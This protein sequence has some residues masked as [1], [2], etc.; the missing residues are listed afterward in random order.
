MRLVPLATSAAASG[1]SD[2]STRLSMGPIRNV[3]LLAVACLSEMSYCAHE[4]KMGVIPIPFI[5]GFTL[6]GVL[7]NTAEEVLSDLKEEGFP[8]YLFLI[9]SFFTLLKLPGPYYPYW[10]RLLIP[11]FAN[12]GLW[13]TVWLIFMWYKGPNVTPEASL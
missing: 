1:G 13:R 9:V 10:G 2:D 5:V 4:R 8:W 3:P 6:A 12:G 7:K 11:H